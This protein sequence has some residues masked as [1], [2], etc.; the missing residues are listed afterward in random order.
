MEQP[1]YLISSEL[2]IFLF[3]L[4]ILALIISVFQLLTISKLRKTPERFD[5][6]SGTDKPVMPPSLVAIQTENVEESQALI[7]SK[8]IEL[9]RIGK[10]NEELIKVLADIRKKVVHLKNNPDSVKRVSK[11][12]LNLIDKESFSSS[13][14]FEMQ[15]NELN[16]E[17]Y[18]QLKKIHPDLTAN[19]LLLCA[20]IKN[21]LDS[22]M[23]ARLLNIKPSS[24]YINRS[25]LRKKL[26]LEPGDDLFSH[27]NSAF[28][29]SAR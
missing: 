27:L 11:E 13:N 26:N 12:L 2:S 20:Y 19:D 17:L 6:D 7:K 1:W 28:Y 18:D 16:Q 22:K 24:V 3:I 23:I 25:R 8:T 4:L 21:G 10:E 15:F 5:G 14:T 9:A 29:E